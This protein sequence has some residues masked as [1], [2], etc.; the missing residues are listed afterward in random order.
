MSREGHWPIVQGRERLPRIGRSGR[1]GRIGRTGRILRALPAWDFA[2]RL[3]IGLIL[4]LVRLAL[5]RLDG[6][7]IGLALVRLAL[8]S[9]GR[10]RRKAHRGA[11]VVFLDVVYV[12]IRILLALRQRRKRRITPATI[13]SRLAAAGDGRIRTGRRVDDFR[14]D[15]FFI[16]VKLRGL[17]TPFAGADFAS[18]GNV[19]RLDGK[20][21]ERRRDHRVRRFALDFDID[22]ADAV[23][24]AFVDRVDDIQLAGLFQEAVVGLD[25]G[26]DVA[27]AAVFVAE[28]LQI[29]VLLVLIEV[30]AG[31][32]FALVGQPAVVEFAV[33]QKT[34]IAHGIPPAFVHHVRDS[35][36]LLVLAGHHFAADLRVKIA[37]AAIVRQELIDVFIDLLGIVLARE[38]IK[39]RRMRLNDGLQALPGNECGADEVDP[40][41]PLPRTFV[42]GVN[43]A[44]ITRLASF[45]DRDA[46]L[47]V[48]VFFVE[49]LDFAT[50]VFHGIGIGRV[51]RFDFSLSFQCLGLVGV[52]ADDFHGLQQRPFRDAKDDDHAARHGQN[53]R[54]DRDEQP[55]ARQG[56]NVVL[57]ALHVVGP[58][59]TGVDLAHD[60]VRGH[61]SVAVHANFH[62]RFFATR[63]R[64]PGLC[65]AVGPAGRRWPC[66]ISGRIRRIRGRKLRTVRRIRRIDAV[67]GNCCGL[68]RRVRRRIVGRRGTQVLGRRRIIRE[69][70]GRS[71]T[72]C[73]PRCA[74]RREHRPV[75]RRRQLARVEP[76]STARTPANA[77]IETARA[78][79]PTRRP[80][81][82]R[83]GCLAMK[84]FQERPIVRGILPAW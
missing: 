54:L 11:S 51:A 48:A 25:F 31:Q 33:T 49:L 63:K 80:W 3:P 84:L 2:R 68:T 75:D 62:N 71:R 8:A 23:A 34:D 76:L 52:V 36:P 6:I 47:A 1:S 42:H 19:A 64:V 30:L 41:D 79:S 78:Q 10:I 43:N 66:R 40:Q 35:D 45:E 17:Q 21:V 9:G 83:F 20:A 7:A 61:G 50:T 38:E 46:D 32:Q 70:A 72:R 59:G 13:I 69:I 44:E 74:R 14:L 24:V 12:Q 81:S 26:E 53:V 67:V 18:V 58:P 27:L 77:A 16:L 22:P 15:A 29:E 5:V 4:D 28:L 56:A 65:R 39:I 37:K 82:V 73:R 55:H 60:L 57:H